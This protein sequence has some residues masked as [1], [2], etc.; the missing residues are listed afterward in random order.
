MICTFSRLRPDN[1]K[2]F[3]LDPVPE[4]N[5]TNEADNNS[6]SSEDDNSPEN[7]QNEVT[8]RETGC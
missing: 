4:M 6:S 8:N 3:L 5:G 1:K 2:S 7:G